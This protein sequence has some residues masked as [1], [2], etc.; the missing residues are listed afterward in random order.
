[1]YLFISFVSLG[2]FLLAIQTTFFSL[3]PHWLGRPDLLFVL[4]VFVA[5][6]FSW[7]SGLFLAFFLG[8]IKDVGSGMFL[9]TYPIMAIIVFC[10]VK[11]CS[12]NSPVKET[13]YQIPLV[14]LSYFVL[15]CILYLIFLLMQP[16]VLPPW[17]WG[18]VIQETFILLVAAIPCFV[19]FNWTYEKI[20]SRRFSPK[21]MRRRS[22]NRFR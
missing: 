21:T 15:Q 2:L 14:G 11:F 1:M 5:Y 18:R 6:R 4:L 17:S 9:G 16:G 12:Q 20:T 19:F 3:F 13:A 7:F 22:G 10:I 8:W